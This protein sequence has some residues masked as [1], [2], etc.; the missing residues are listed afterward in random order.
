[1][2]ALASLILTMA[3]SMKINYAG[4]KMA[5][6]QKGDSRLTTQAEIEKQFK[7]IPDHGKSFPGYGG[8]PVSHYKGNYYI[9]TAT[10]HTIVIGTSRSGKGQTLVNPLISRIVAMSFCEPR[11]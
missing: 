3:L 4:K 2:L 9:D 10:N 5:Y 1:M 7:K 11:S 8:I 6:G